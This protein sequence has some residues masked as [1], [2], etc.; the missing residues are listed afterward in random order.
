MASKYAEVIKSLTT[1][2]GLEPEYQEKVNAVKRK[3]LEPIPDGVEQEEFPS[4]AVEDFVGDITAMLQVLNDKMI[5]AVAGDRKAVQ[6]ARVFR[7]LRTIKSALEQQEK[8]TNVL[9]DAYG[10]LL[11]DQY[12]VEGTTSITLTDG[13]K[14]RTQYEPHAK[15]VDK[16]ANRKWAIANG[17]ENSLT[18]PWQ[19]VNALTKEALLN[20]DDAPDGVEAISRPKI[21]YTKG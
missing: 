19:T 17:L 12:E 14:V 6:L 18:L 15:V 4:S 2:F 7:D 3:I 8:V 20:G 1:S 13:G 10:Q 5:R 11:V 21:V 16:D 9:L